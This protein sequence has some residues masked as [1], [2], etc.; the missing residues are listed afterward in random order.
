MKR[1]ARPLILVAAAGLTLVAA[2]V[3]VVGYFWPLS[4]EVRRLQKTDSFELYSLEPLKEDGRSDDDPKDSGERLHG[5]RIL[6]KMTVSEESTRYQ[7]I[8]ALKEN[9]SWVGVGDKCFDPRH[10]IRRKNDGETVDLIICF[11]CNNV[12]MYRN[13]ERVPGYHY[14]RGAAQA[15]FDE[16]LREAGIPLARKRKTH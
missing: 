7:L 8:E 10:A 11:E 9:M 4:G 3:F 15:T 13:G 1:L 5:W 12:V 14:V 16:V 2:G 6:G